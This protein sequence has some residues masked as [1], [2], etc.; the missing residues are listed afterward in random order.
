MTNALDTKAVAT[1][2]SQRDRDLYVLRT[3]GCLVLPDFFDKDLLDEAEKRAYE[4][5]KEI[6]A[7][8]ERFGQVPKSTGWPLKNTRC[9]YA[10]D[11]VFERLIMDTG[12]VELARGYLGNCHLRDIHLLINHPDPRNIKRGRNADVNWHRDKEWATGEAIRP[13]YLHSFIPLTDM[14]RDNGGTLVIPGTHREREPGY[15]FYKTDPGKKI[16]ENYYLVYPQRYFPGAMQV[17]ARRGSLVLF[18]P[19]TIHSQGINITTDKRTVLNAP[20]HRSDV[21]AFIDCRTIAEKAARYKMRPEF[22][23]LLGSGAGLTDSYGPLGAV[24]A[25]VN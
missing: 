16:D 3:S 12:L 18:D 17:E 5:E 22:F 13:T 24:H 1:D 10:V 25:G 11:Q 14:T 15:Y 19:M 23:N 4:F 20:F 8:V 7:H 21:P 9:L 6:D 2:V